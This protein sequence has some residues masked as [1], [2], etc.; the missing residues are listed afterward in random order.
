M[1][2]IIAV[3][4][5]HESLIY[6]ELIA[7]IEMLSG[8]IFIAIIA[9]FF[10]SMTLYGL[11][12]MGGLV[13][14]LTLPLRL[15]MVLIGGYPV[16]VLAVLLLPVIQ[17]TV[18][19]L[20]GIE[21]AKPILMIWGAFYIATLLYQSFTLKEDDEAMPVKVVKN[22]RSLVLAMI[23]AS[24]VLGAIGMG[25]LGGILLNYGFFKL[26]HNFAIVI[27]IIY[28]IMILAV[29]IVVMI[30]LRILSPISASSKSSENSEIAVDASH[31]SLNTAK[32]VIT[33]PPTISEKM[34]AQKQKR[35]SKTPQTERDID[36]LVRRK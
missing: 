21:A 27:G 8:A 19:T 7:T 2:E 9:G 22:L 23:S 31:H 11:K 29:E 16:I 4:N 5:T 33:D 14:L 35:T 10:I 13:T 32:I 25:G 34:I 20:A 26:D 30:V 15:V 28:G 18:G 3:I 1:N 17:S 6:S 12:R 24:A 36:A